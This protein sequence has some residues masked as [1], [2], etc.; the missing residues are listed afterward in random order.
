MDLAY[1]L[2]DLVLTLDREAEARLRLVGL[3]YRWYVALLIAIEHPG[4][5]SRDLARGL[6]VSD[7]ATSGVVRR[8]IREGL[9][10]DLAPAGSGNIRRLSV[11][12]R[13]R[14]AVAQ[15]TD[16]LGTAFDDNV[17]RIGAD[18]IDLA[19]TIRA[20]HDEVRRAGRTENERPASTDVGSRPGPGKD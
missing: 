13:G 20:I 2:H 15:A 10:R 18:P 12:D 3:T 9:V 14:R 19:R 4:L 6:G 11:T 1:E 8:L 7:P 17:R 5:S 16:L